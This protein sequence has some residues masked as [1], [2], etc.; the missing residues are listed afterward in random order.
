MSESSDSDTTD[1][2]STDSDTS[3]S[4]S[5]SSSSDLDTLLEIYS[6]VKQQRYITDRSRNPRRSER[7]IDRLLYWEQRNP[8]RFRGLIRM[9]PAAFRDLVHKLLG[10]KPFQTQDRAPRTWDWAAERVLWLYTG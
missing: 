4:S 3:T 7:M 5:S 6:K 2:D 10:T 9:K 1:S 8:L